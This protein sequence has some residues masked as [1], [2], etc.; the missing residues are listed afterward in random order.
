VTRLSRRAIV[1]A[2][3]LLASTSAQAEEKS[4]ALRIDRGKVP[5]AS[6]TMKVL[7][8]DTVRL[9]VTTDRAVVLHVHGLKIE[10]PAAPD[11]PGT[12][13]FAASATGRFPVHLHAANDAHS[14]H[15]GAPLAYLEVHPR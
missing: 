9:D 10:I 6:R 13:T 7:K 5:P 4:F 14:H 2:A 15:H 11:K 1:G 3:L 8:G 12:A